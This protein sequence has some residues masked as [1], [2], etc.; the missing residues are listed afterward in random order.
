VVAGLVSIFVAPN[1]FASSEYYYEKT[2][3]YLTHNPTICMIQPM[4]SNYYPAILKLPQMTVDAMTDWSN[5][6]ND[7][8]DVFVMSYLLVPYNK[9]QMYDYTKC[10]IT[11][12]YEPQPN[13]T[14][15]DTEP[16]GVT[17][18]DF[19]NHKAS[20][21]I[22][23][24]LVDYYTEIHAQYEKFAPYYTDKFASDAQLQ[25]TIR[26]ELGHAFGLGHYV[27]NTTTSYSPIICSYNCNSNPPNFDVG[28]DLVDTP[29]LMITGIG[30]IGYDQANKIHVKPQDVDELKSLYGE[31]GFNATT[32]RITIMPSSSPS[33]PPPITVKTDK[34]SYKTGDSVVVSGTIVDPFDNNID[35]FVYDPSGN[36]V[37]RT[38]PINADGT[39]AYTFDVIITSGWSLS[40]TYKVDASW[41]PD[42]WTTF[43]FNS[44]LQSTHHNP[45]SQPSLPVPTPS[46]PTP[47]TPSAPQV[48]PVSITP[49]LSITD[50][51]E[52]FKNTHGNVSNQ[53]FDNMINYLKIKGVLILPPTT[54][55]V[56]MP[57]WF[58]NNIMYWAE[59]LITDKEF[60][61]GIQFLADKE[62]IKI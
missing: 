21:I 42:A 28:K 59:N 55:N 51:K 32:Q 22:Y 3:F 41:V 10:D 43:Y 11:V 8:K 24:N 12:S 53:D 26:H 44:T 60:T 37:E 50:Y 13:S 40:G 9:A 36:F 38:T 15:S 62:I 23:Y 35:I 58:K 17:Q 29:S 6:L 34:Q 54:G 31:S 46:L 49:V 57:S 19:Q 14:V 1:V 4:D 25:F 52:K 48:P 47:V 16:I 45:Q 56:S 20:I 7:P 2:G 39:Y 33:T 27:E 30:P 61:D 5:L 18:Y